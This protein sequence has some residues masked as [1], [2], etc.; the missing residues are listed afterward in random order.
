[1]SAMSRDLPTSQQV[2]FQLHFA[3]HINLLL[4]SGRTL[5]PGHGVYVACQPDFLSQT[6]LCILKLF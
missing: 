1:M 6:H 3:Q 4:I 5:S 2:Y